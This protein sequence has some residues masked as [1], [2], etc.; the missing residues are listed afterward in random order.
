MKTL[1]AL[2]LA[3]T[4]PLTAEIR[5]PQKPLSTRGPLDMRYIVG[6]VPHAAGIDVYWMHTNEYRLPVRSKL[7]RTTVSS[8]GASRLSTVLIREFDGWVAAQV[9][10]EG[11]NVQ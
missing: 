7:M 11:A 3:L 5:I 2:V 1:L 6:L 8:D 10:G 9:D 4:V